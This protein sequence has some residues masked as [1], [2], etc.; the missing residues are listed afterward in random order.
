MWVGCVWWICKW[1]RRWDMAMPI[2]A[3]PVLRGKRADMFLAKIER[4]SKQTVEFVPTPKLERIND[5]IR[6]SARQ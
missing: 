5:V 2:G 6:K 4:E 1:F 3:T